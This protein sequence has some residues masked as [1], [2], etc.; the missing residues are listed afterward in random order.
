MTRNLPLVLLNPMF[1]QRGRPL[2]IAVV[3]PC[4]RVTDAIFGVLQKIGDEVSMIFVI[5]DK[6]PDGLCYKL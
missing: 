2:V 5:D 3:I 4:F 1:V 6:C